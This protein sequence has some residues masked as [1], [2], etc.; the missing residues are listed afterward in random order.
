MALLLDSTDAER[1]AFDAVCTRLGGF[2]PRV[3][4]E[5]ADGYL[6]GVLAGP[7]AVGLDEWLPRMAGDAFERAFADPEDAAQARAALVSRARAL[8]SQL[9]PEGLLDQPEALRLLPLVGVWDDAAR[10]SLV[11]DQGVS[12]EDAAQMVTG[13]LWA[14]GFFDALEDFADDWHTD[15]ADDEAREVFDELLAQVTVLLMADDHAEFKAHLDTVWKDRLPTREDLLDEA[16]FAIQDLRVWWLDHAPRPETRRVEATP[17][18]NDPC[19]C[20]SGQKFKK[21]HGK[22]A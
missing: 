6:T 12:P 3:M 18:R 1:E 21:C 20:G 17:G 19:P 11:K 13:A 10:E 22:A 8:A 2:N 7:R 15:A 9:D 14:E 16:C 4:T 5:W